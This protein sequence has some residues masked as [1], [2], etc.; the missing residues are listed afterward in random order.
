MS[1]TAAARAAT[2]P[3]AEYK[4]IL[5]RVL[6]NRPSGTRQRLATALGTNRSFVSQIAN[7]AYAMPIPM[8]HLDAIFEVCHFSQAE[9][10]DFRDAYARA[11]PD[12]QEGGDAALK[13]RVISVT[14]ADLGD[15]RRNRALD[16]MVARFARQVS[17]F[18]EDFDS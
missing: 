6:E 8:Q 15:A 18:A 13:P 3:V 11:H 4:R 12:R 16:E 7:P 2:F 9:R 1:E 17:R 10:S 5:Q 14:V